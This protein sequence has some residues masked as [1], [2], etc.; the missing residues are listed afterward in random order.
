MAR[1]GHDSE[2]AARGADNEITEAMDAHLEAERT[3]DEVSEDG[4]GGA[5]PG[6]LI[7]R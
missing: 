4:A 1:M 2:R 3:D 5:R 6:G 7:A